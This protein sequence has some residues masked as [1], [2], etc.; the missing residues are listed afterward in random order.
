MTSTRARQIFG[1]NLI[2]PVSMLQA[3]LV[4]GTRKIACTLA[5]HDGNSYGPLARGSRARRPRTVR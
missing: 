4:P 2:H 1:N 3:R 5:A